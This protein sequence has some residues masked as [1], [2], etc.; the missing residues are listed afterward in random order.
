LAPL[1]KSLQG[2]LPSMSV[3][4]FFLL[5]KALIARI[6]NK[7]LKLVAIFFLSF[8]IFSYLS[9]SLIHLLLSTFSPLLCSF[10]FF[11][12]LFFSFFLVA[13]P[14]EAT[15]NTRSQKRRQRAGSEVPFLSFAFLICP[16]PFSISIYP[17]LMTNPFI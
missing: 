4:V 15:A 5:E 14:V 13:I 1:L 3:F 11:S 8:I 7:S 17:T 12:F 2:R 9:S 6:W 10:L 16:Y